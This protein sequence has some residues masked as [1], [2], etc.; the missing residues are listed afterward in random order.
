MS[1]IPA[2]KHSNLRQTGMRAIL[3][4]FLLYQFSSSQWATSTYADSTLCVCPGFNQGILT[5]DDGSSIICGALDDSRYV[6]KLDPYG[7]K[8]WPQPIQVYNTPH[9]DNDGN[10]LD[11]ISDGQGGV[12][13]WWADFRGAE[14]G[15]FGPF[16]NAIYT[17]R[18]DKNGNVVW[19][20]GG[21]QLA[22]VEG[23]IQGGYGVSDGQGGIIW[24]MVASDFLRTNASR[25][26]HSWLIAY[27]TNGQKKW[28]H[29]ID[30]STIQYHLSVGQP[31]K[32]GNKI[33]IGTL[34]GPRFFEPNSGEYA[35][36][37]NIT[38]GWE[39]FITEGDTIAFRI[40]PRPTEYDS[41]GSL[42]Y[43]VY[44]ITKFNQQWDSVWGYDLRFKFMTQNPEMG[45]THKNDRHLKKTTGNILNVFQTDRVGGLFF[46][47]GTSAGSSGVQL[48]W[49][50]KDG[51]HFGDDEVIIPLSGFGIAF[52][53]KGKYGI[54][55]AGT[56]T[57]QEI[58]TTGKLLWPSSLQV[59]SDPSNAY[60][61]WGASDNNGGGIIIFWTTLGGIYAQHTGR[62]GKVGVI[63]KAPS[64]ADAPLEFDLSQNFPN[65]FNPTTIINFEV[66]RTSFTT[67][68]IFDVLGRKVATL[69]AEELRPGHYSR[70]WYA[71]NY[72][73]GI[74]FYQLQS[75]A[76]TEIRKMLLVK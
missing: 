21:I 45:K 66:P 11:I 26:E 60:S 18:V 40:T 46:A 4:G 62:V 48:R 37:P 59:I 33:M 9:T 43:N 6:Q 30:S 3:L 65:P 54:Y 56:G 72:S 25:T 27:D 70:K 58:D 41:S 76:S 31:I 7:Y 57:A 73:S 67:L 61:P 36:S 69:V 71:L 44:E 39:S 29:P 15:E 5:F 50:T 63:A 19:Q 64:V 35:Q 23:G 13:L 28:A 53:G 47:Y 38:S 8:V 42:Y 12:I 24:Y 74:Y 32:L 16:N 20:N 22:P 75:G 1:G 34:N 2:S 14:Y 10:A 55:D 51:P 52:N 17:Q 68:K 49:I